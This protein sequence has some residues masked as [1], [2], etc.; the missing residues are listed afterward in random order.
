MKNNKKLG[1]TLAEVLIVLAV[2]G[3]VAIL[4]IPSVLK[5][6]Q[7]SQARMKIKKSM[8]AYDTAINKMVIENDLRGESALR[9]WAN[10]N[11]CENSTEYFKKVER[12][13]CI[14][15]TADGVW[16]DIS[17]IMNPI[18]SFDKIDNNVEGK[19]SADKRDEADDMNYKK[20]FAFVANFDNNGSLRV[21][22]LAFEK[23]NSYDENNSDDNMIKLYSF[24]NPAAT[25]TNDNSTTEDDSNCDTACKY[26]RG[27]F[28]ETCPASC[29]RNP[30]DCVSCSMYDGSNRSMVIYDS[31]GEQVGSIYYGGPKEEIRVANSY[32]G[33]SLI[34]Y[35][36][37]SYCRKDYDG[38]GHFVG[39]SGASCIYPEH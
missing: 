39:Q 7:E 2:L 29:Y 6:Y 16:W 32:G 28:S 1:F 34:T 11:N 33:E 19:T 24:I 12:D 14:F 23:T 9:D 31:S 36:E 22:D 38:D 18:I 21:N 8:A 20:T 26:I 13:G 25:L 15:K 5:K 3:I 10:S 35:G 30:E 4:T 17:D 37:D 27:D